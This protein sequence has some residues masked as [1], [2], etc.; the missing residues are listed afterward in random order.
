MKY[1]NLKSV[2]ILILTLLSFSPKSIYKYNS[3]DFTKYEKKIDLSY[4]VSIIDYCIV[5]DSNNNG[6]CLGEYYFIKNKSDTFNLITTSYGSISDSTVKTFRYS[7][8]WIFLPRKDTACFEFYSQFNL[9]KVIDY[10]YPILFGQIAQG[11]D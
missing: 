6:L 5:N 8:S 10:K 1:F 4:G 2:C 9:K 11:L 3:C 7:S